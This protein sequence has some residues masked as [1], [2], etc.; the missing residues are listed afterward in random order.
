M[1]KGH[2]YLFHFLQKNS[3][4]FNF[5][6]ICFST[7]GYLLETL[8]GTFYFWCCPN[9]SQKLRFIPQIPVSLMLLGFSLALENEPL[10]HQGSSPIKIHYCHFTLLKQMGH[11]SM[12]DTNAFVESFFL[13]S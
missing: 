5:P 9:P 10:Q 12:S 11:N 4:P 7:N 2:R 13:I 1:F 6:L 8:L 3:V